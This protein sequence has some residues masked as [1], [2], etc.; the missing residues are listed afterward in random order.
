MSKYVP[1]KLQIDPKSVEEIITNEGQILRVGQDNTLV[2]VNSVEHAKATPSPAE[3]K[4]KL[5][6]IKSSISEKDGTWFLITREL[7]NNYRLYS[8]AEQVG[9]DIKYN[10]TKKV[11]NTKPVSV[12]IDEDTELRDI[13]ETKSGFFNPP[14][15]VIKFGAKNENIVAAHSIVE[16]ITLAVDNM[17]EAEN[18]TY[19]LYGE[20]LWE[21]F[22]NPE[23]DDKDVEY[24]LKKTG[25]VNS[26]YH[27]KLNKAI[28]LLALILFGNL[29][30]D[31]SLLEFQ[32][33]KDGNIK[34]KGKN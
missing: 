31:G 12:V 21:H 7:L 1:K 15:R 28:S 11:I 22:M 26:T 27:D 25:F 13:L 2:E 32:I 29:G 30:P 34:I 4:K 5:A 19:N 10:A 17:I 23:N 9:S 16:I 18:K 33:E 14:K 8:F 3:V 20:L 24:L 6:Y